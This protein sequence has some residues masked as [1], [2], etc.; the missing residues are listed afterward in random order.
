MAAPWRFNSGGGLA[1]LR[2]VITNI[3]SV[4]TRTIAA[5]VALLLALTL[6]LSL[7]I[8][9]LI[10]AEASVQHTYDVLSRIN[11]TER[12]LIDQETGL[13]GYLLA[14]QPRFLQPFEAGRRQFGPSLDALARETVDNPRQQVRIAAALDRYRSWLGNVESE[15]RQ[16]PSDGSAPL[17]DRTLVE[18]MDAR[19]QDM[20]AMRATFVSLREEEDRLL[21]VRQRRATRANAILFSGG[22]LVVVVCAVLLVIFL[23]RQIALIDQIY[24]EKVTES[25]RA[26]QAAEAMAD[27]VREQSA[28]VEAALL[29]ANRER[30]AAIQR[31]SASGRR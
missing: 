8:V 1:I 19:K 25:E 15:M 21:I 29:T 5:P 13:R 20:D 28:A 27:E 22:G 7:W 26:R 12:L 4:V 9:H 17:H 14:P 31:L 10:Q 30:D 3:K 24:G 23:R 18:R 2:I 6:A 11:E 16:V